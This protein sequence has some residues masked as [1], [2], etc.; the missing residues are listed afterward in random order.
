MEIQLIENNYV[1]VKSLQDYEYYINYL[2]NYNSLGLDI[3][4]F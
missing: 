1:Y 2:E 3:E 4:T